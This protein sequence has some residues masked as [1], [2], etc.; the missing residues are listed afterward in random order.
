MA[1]IYDRLPVIDETARMVAMIHDELIIECLH[2]KAEKVLEM[3][4]NIMEEAG[5]EIL[6]DEIAL[7][8]EGSYAESWGQAK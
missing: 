3:A 7:I 2:E 1:V 4:K 5:K 8:A 6:G